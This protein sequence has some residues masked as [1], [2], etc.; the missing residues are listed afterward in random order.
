M[1]FAEVVKLEANQYRSFNITVNDDY[2]YGPFA[3]DYLK[4]NT[5]H[6]KLAERGSSKYE[7]SI[8]KA[9]QSTLPPI[10]NAIEVYSVKDLLQSETDQGDGT[11]FHTLP[12]Y[13]Y[14]CVCTFRSV[15]VQYLFT[16]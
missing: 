7:V 11:L 2:W 6:S 3:P 13:I 9:E 14:V 15:Y 16:M 10:I 1:H 4:A 12:I 8:V 5:L